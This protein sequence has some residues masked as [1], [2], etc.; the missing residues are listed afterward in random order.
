MYFCRKN[1]ATSGADV[2]PP[3]PGPSSTSSLPSPSPVVI[4]DDVVS[5]DGAYKL[6]QQCAKLLQNRVFI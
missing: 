1:Q 5:A 6:Q 4:S 2:V 3:P